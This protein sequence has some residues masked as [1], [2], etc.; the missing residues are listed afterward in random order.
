MRRCRRQTKKTRKLRA[1]AAN[2]LLLKQPSGA[3]DA[4]EKAVRNCVPSRSAA[5][6][7]CEPRRDVFVTSRTVTVTSTPGGTHGAVADLDPETIVLG[8]ITE[9]ADSICITEPVNG[10][11]QSSPTNSAVVRAR[12][13]QVKYAIIGAGQTGLQFLHTCVVKQSGS[14]AMIDTRDEIG[15]HWTD[16]YA[17]VK[18][19]TPKQTYGIDPA[20]WFGDRTRDLATRDEILDHYSLTMRSSLEH[21]DV[22]MFLG[23]TAERVMTQA[24]GACVLCNPVTTG[25]RRCWWRVAL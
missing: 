8:T 7:D 24:L 23:H 11:I 3:C 1:E 14:V 16:Q 6:S 25:R 21:K 5:V 4:I 9:D 10:W 2:V 18:L 20:A 17:F 12:T 19:H 13:V 15:G 22:A